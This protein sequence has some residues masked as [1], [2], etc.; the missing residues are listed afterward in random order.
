M[1]GEPGSSGAGRV[2]PEVGNEAG[3]V[4]FHEVDRSRWAD[5]ERLFESRG[6]PK[7]CW[8]MV[9]RGAPE[10]RK[11]AARRKVALERRVAAG[12]PVGLLGYVEG[13]PVA[14][15]SIAP[16]PTYRALGGIDEP[17]E[18]PDDV[19]SVVCFFITRRM[20]GRGLMKRLLE[21]AVAR[22]RA[23]G[24]KVVEAYPVDPDSPSY[25]FMGFVPAFEAAGF[26]RVGR[27]GSR[28]HVMRRALG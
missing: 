24:A 7:H 20:R 2:E 9:W 3:R 12:E 25:R 10:E 6:G 5:L 28:R 19:W 17:G 23:R 1:D 14:W 22:A 13:E 11:G 15:C 4:T 18:A 21:E 27:A 26:R 8:C 16:R